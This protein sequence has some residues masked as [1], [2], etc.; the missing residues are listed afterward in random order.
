L[1]QRQWFI[2]RNRKFSGTA[3]SVLVPYR[4]Q[5]VTFLFRS[6]IFSVTPNADVRTKI[7]GFAM[8]SKQ[9]QTHEMLG[10]VVWATSGTLH[11]LSKNI[12]IKMLE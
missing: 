7:V 3:D 4:E 9:P 12:K 10:D 11:H 6:T 2:H 5:Q 8:I 1:P